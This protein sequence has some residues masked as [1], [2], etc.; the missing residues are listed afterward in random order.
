MAGVLGVVMKAASALN[1]GVY[2]L[3]KGRVMGKVKGHPVA[4]LT[5]PGR[6]SGTP[7]TTPVLIFDQGGSHLVAGSAGGQ[8]AE[9]QWFRNLRAADRATLEVKD[10][11]Q[12][13]AVAMVGDGEYPELWADVVRRAPFFGDYERKAAGRQ[14]PLARLTPVP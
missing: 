9:P 13:V 10:R 7:R 3:S 2:R 6:K 14:I 1:I 11:R 8:A 12:T 5:V 4:L